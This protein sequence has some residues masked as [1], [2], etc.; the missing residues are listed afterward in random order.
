[1][2]QQAEP[3]RVHFCGLVGPRA[4]D[5]PQQRSAAGVVRGAIT[6]FV[7]WFSTPRPAESVDEQIAALGR[8]YSLDAEE[9]ARASALAQATRALALSA[10]EG[11]VA[12]GVADPV[13]LQEPLSPVPA[14][15]VADLIEIIGSHAAADVLD[16]GHD[17]LEAALRAAD[18]DAALAA[19]FLLDDIG[20][21]G[22]GGDEEWEGEPGE[23][24]EDVDDDPEAHPAFWWDKVRGAANDH[25]WA[26][27]LIRGVL[28]K[29]RR[30]PLQKPARRCV[31]SC[32]VA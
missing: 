15:L 19:D 7:K 11:F 27:R 6:G 25:M 31:D 21:G 4:D 29:H 1:M 12:A 18:G 28:D 9:Y 13:V 14:Q 20:E 5:P 2:E 26:S 23:E 3:T 24:A 16:F 32:V 17:E 22:D 30:A 10:Q 8:E